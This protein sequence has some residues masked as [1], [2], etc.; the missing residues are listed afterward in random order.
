[1]S[2]NS[3]PVGYN[4]DL[5]HRSFDRITSKSF[6]VR[7]I[8]GRGNISALGD[9]LLGTNGNI[10]AELAQDLVSPAL[11]FNTGGCNF[12]NGNCGT[13]SVSSPNSS[14]CCS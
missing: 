10:D 9:T 5:N 6:G 2:S 8:A 12:L 13:D 4:C 1:M 7:Y 14:G 3:N 11:K